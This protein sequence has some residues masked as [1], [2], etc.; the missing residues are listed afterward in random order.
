[1][2]P[3]AAPI[4]LP[5]HARDEERR[6]RPRE[7]RHGA[8]STRARGEMSRGR[9]FAPLAAPSERRVGVLHQFLELSREPGTGQR[10]VGESAGHAVAVALVAAVR[11]IAH[12]I[13]AFAFVVLDLHARAVGFARR[14]HPDVGVDAGLW[15]R[16]RALAEAR[17][18]LIAPVTSVDPP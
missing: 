6:K 3:H 7:R 1:R 13:E 16:A 9:F 18:G 15:A 4:A 8:E 17:A 14:L 11:G 10:G 5:E 12:P 2:S